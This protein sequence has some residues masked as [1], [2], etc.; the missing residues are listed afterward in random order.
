MNMRSLHSQFNTAK[1]GG[2]SFSPV[3]WSAINA[4]SYDRTPE[5][6]PKGPKVNM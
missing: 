4:L 5:G 3:I 2:V 1:N 6:Q